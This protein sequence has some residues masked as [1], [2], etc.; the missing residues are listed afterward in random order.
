MKTKLILIG[1]LALNSAMYAQVPTAGL[2]S[3]W[4]FSGVLTD[5]VGTNN[6][7][8]SGSGSAT[9]AMDR[10]NTPGS[11]ITLN[12]SNYVQM[13]SAG[14][15]GNSARSISLWMRTTAPMN[16]SPKAMICYGRAL[17]GCNADAFEINYDYGLSGVGPDV[18]SEQ[19][20]YCKNCLNDGLWHHVVATYPG[21]NSSGINTIKMY[22]D[23]VLISS[24]CQGSGTAVL[25]TL[26]DVGIRIGCNVQPA[27]NTS[28]YYVGDLDDFYLY[29][30][31]LSPSD[32]LLLYNDKCTMIPSPIPC[33][34][35]GGGGHTDPKGDCCLGNYCSAAPN[36]LTGDYQIAIDKFNFN[37]TTGDMQRGKVII[38]RSNC[39]I[40]S[41]RL[42]VMDD[43]I[44]TGIIGKAM[45]QTAN[46]VGVQGIG[47]HTGP[48]NSISS[49]GVLGEVDNTLNRSAGIAGFCAG[50]S[51]LAFLP[52]NE[53]IGVY[54]NSLANGGRW[55]G[56]FDGDV[57]I[58]GT[59][60]YNNFTFISS[61]IRYK[62]NIKRIEDVTTKLAKI[63][64]YT[65]DYKLEE[66]KEM[67]F[68]KSKQIG[69]IAQEIKEVFPELVTES[70]KGYLAVNYEG[71]IPVLLEAIKEQQDQ[72]NELKAAISSLSI[73]S[74]KGNKQS[75]SKITVL[76]LSDKNAIV[77]NQNVP[78]PFAETTVINYN[79]PTDF[80]KAQILFSTSDG[81]VIKVV[82]ITEKGAGSL[83]VF[84]NDLTHGLYSYTLVVDGK[85]IDTK[86]MIKE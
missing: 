67:N 3:K 80:G 30:T 60:W 27:P 7:T 54:G 32:V 56:Y 33:T 68:S 53:S 78:N 21:G 13:T 55:A 57:N 36:V 64:G 50:P 76:E 62:K 84:A 22:V 72:I 18:C 23:G 16:G 25:N 75:T 74:K 31:V 65:Y 73:D 15:T 77:L 28:R 85:T 63:S 71:M 4:E 5:G 12:G 43:Q 34:Q 37:F 9:Y 8:W 14:P 52:I 86:K 24:S 45:A 46:V 61:D 17:S 83:S 66:F 82:E 79:V 81:K 38:G 59:A 6:G 58:I 2:I 48:G 26:N 42:D 51:N 11:A 47:S 40:G 10:C 39:A 20:T 49:I 70:A 44:G 1:L 19:Y 69:L 35:T 41:A 29:N